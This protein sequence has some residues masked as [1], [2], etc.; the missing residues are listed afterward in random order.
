MHHAPAEE[1]DPLKES[2]KWLRPSLTGRF[3]PTGHAALQHQQM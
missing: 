3:A 1:F 2:E